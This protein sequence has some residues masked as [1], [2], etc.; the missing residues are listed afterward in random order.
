MGNKLT[1]FAWRYGLRLPSQARPNLD[2]PSSHLFWINFSVNDEHSSQI[3]TSW[4]THVQSFRIFNWF[5]RIHIV[6]YRYTLSSYGST[7]WCCG[8]GSAI[9]RAPG[10]YNWEALLIQP[11]KPWLRALFCYQR[12]SAGPSLR[13]PSRVSAIDRAAQQKR[14]IFVV[15]TGTAE[16]HGSKFQLNQTSKDIDHLS[17]TPGTLSNG[18]FNCCWISAR[19]K[20]A[21]QST[22][23]VQQSRSKRFEILKPRP[24]P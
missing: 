14:F 11:Y 20:R 22:A 12:L 4:L 1:C 17:S 23:R 24:V 6:E 10:F 18:S 13:L 21:V 15:Q 5:A 16:F 2:E 8:S 9:V 7:L 19:L 3:Q